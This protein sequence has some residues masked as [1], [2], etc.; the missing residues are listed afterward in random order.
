M[1]SELQILVI[2]DP[3]FRSRYIRTVDDFTTQVLELIKA[4]NPDMIVVLGDTLHDH[5]TAN[6]EC[7]PRAVNWFIEMSKHAHVVVLIGNHERPNNSDFL[8]NRH[9]F[10]G[11]GRE[12]LL[13][14][15]KP[16]SLTI[17]KKGKDHRLV[18]VPYVPPGRFHEA[19]SKLEVPIT[20]VKPLAIFA[21]QEFKGCQMGIIKSV[22]GDEWPQDGPLVI[23]GH[24]HEHE[25]LGGNI[26]YVGTPYQTTY[27]EKDEKGVYIF[28]LGGAQ[29]GVKRVHLKLR[30][31]LN[32]NLT[33]VEFA[34]FEIT[35]P[36]ADWRIR[37]QGPQEAVDAVKFSNKYKD[38]KAKPNIK[39]QII[40]ILAAPEVKHNLAKKN[41]VDAL[42]EEVSQKPYLKTLCQELIDSVK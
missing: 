31:K 1:S 17:T 39:I 2:G 4:R 14:V 19:L 15:D 20:S 34:S 40:P 13:I 22:E 7:Q 25:I 29:L 12:R 6:I 38:W 41:Y 3:H 33:P 9:F 18:F 28:Q 24:I 11:I 42:A 27:A 21:H 16:E 30:I 5:E 10:N 8:T 23:S 35:N 32:V 26:I 37:I 36:N